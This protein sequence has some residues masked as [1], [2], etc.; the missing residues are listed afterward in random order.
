LH[1]RL[2]ASIGFLAP[3]CGITQAW[4]PAP[5]PAHWRAVCLELHLGSGSFGRKSAR[6]PHGN[7]TSQH[8]LR[9][10]MA[11]LACANGAASGAGGAYPKCQRKTLCGP[12]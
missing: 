5:Q 12:V 11:S 10:A 6:Y 1:E 8:A 7:A 3:A 2:L 9:P 4:L